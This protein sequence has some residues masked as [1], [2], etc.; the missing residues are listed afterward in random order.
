MSSADHASSDSFD[1][2]RQWTGYAAGSARNFARIAR[3]G[4]SSEI[5]DHESNYTGPASDTSSDASL[6]SYVFVAVF[7]AVFSDCW[8]PKNS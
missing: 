6:I 4:I 5:V 2:A 7:L 1:S 8:I 3:H